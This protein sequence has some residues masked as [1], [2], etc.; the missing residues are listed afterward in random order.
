MKRKTL[1]IPWPDFHFDLKAKSLEKWL[2]TP[3]NLLIS[4]LVLGVVLWTNGAGASGLGAPMSPHSSTT[5]ISYQGRLADSSGNPLTTAGVAMQFRLYA[6]N[7]GG[8]PLWSETQAAVPVEDGLFHTLLGSTTPIP[9]SLL[10]SNNLLWLGVTVGADSE[11]MPREQLASVPYAMVASTVP[12]ESITADKLSPDVFNVLG[13]S[14]WERDES[15]TSNPTVISQ[16]N[17]LV[18]HGYAQHIVTAADITA[19]FYDHSVALPVPFKAGTVPTVLLT[20][21]GESGSAGDVLKGGVTNGAGGTL[22][23]LLSANNTSFT[24]RGSGG[25]AGRRD[26]FHWIAIGQK[27]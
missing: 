9:V 20:Y 2:P 4:L 25:Y 18:Q 23:R 15:S 10:A 22:G 17:I 13:L 16:S 26:G 3:G 7:T 27:P 19:Q 11:M 1:S 8:S 12:D 14:G 5:T 21:T 24:I 6:A